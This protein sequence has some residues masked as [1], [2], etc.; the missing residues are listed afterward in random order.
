MAGDGILYFVA[1]A[2]RSGKSKYTRK[3]LAKEPKTLVWDVKDEYARPWDAKAERPDRTK[4]L[5][6]WIITKTKDQ[7][8]KALKEKHQGNFK[9]CHVSDRME[10]FDYWSRCAYAFGK[11]VEMAI[12][13]EELA[14]VTN[15]S[16][17]PPGWGNVCRKL[18]GFGCNVYAITQRP[19]ES[20]KTA[21]GNATV[22]HCCRL[23]NLTDIKRMSQQLNVPLEQVNGLKDREYIQRWSSGELKTGKV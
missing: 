4:I 22:V 12:V 21:L 11:I 13:G 16:K 17:A 20:D 18:L 8:I 9:I 19:A 7:L 6:G 1:G 3:L 15:P 23:N 10:D 14:D 5:R 2:S